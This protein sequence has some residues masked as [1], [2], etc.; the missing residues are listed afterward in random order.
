MQLA[1]AENHFHLDRIFNWFSWLPAA[2]RSVTSS[3]TWKPVHTPGKSGDSTSG[4]HFNSFI[5]PYSLSKTLSASSFPSSPKTSQ[6][7]AASPIVSTPDQLQASS[8]LG[9]ALA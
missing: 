2:K 7:P 3:T 5:V 8:N 1:Y 4:V 6:P 9:G